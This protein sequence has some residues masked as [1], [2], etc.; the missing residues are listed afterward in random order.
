MHS[1]LRGGVAYNVVYFSSYTSAVE[2]KSSLKVLFPFSSL[3]HIAIFLLWV[4][5]GFLSS[6][7]FHGH[8]ISCP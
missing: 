4:L 3:H 5:G 7:V 6:C 8:V 1:G 2:L